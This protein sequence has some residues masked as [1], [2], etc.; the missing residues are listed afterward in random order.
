MSPPPRIKSPDDPGLKVLCDQLAELAPALETED[1]WPAHQLELCGQYGV[2]EWFIPQELGGQGW[3][4]ADVVAGYLKLSEACLTTTFVITQRTGACRRIAHCGN[5]WAREQCL[6]ALIEGR[7]F[8]TVGISH[9]TTS[10]RHLSRPAL[11]A[12]PVDGGIVLD[13]FSPW[14]TGAAFADWIVT[15]AI[16]DDASQ[17]L[18][19]VPRDLAGVTAEPTLALMGLSAS[20]TGPV[21]FDQ[22]EV[23]AS[24]ILAGPAQDV[25]RSGIGA[26]SGG[27]QTSTL[28]TGLSDAAI[29]YLEAQ[30]VDRR[31]LMPIAEAV[32]HEWTVLRDHL[33]QVAGGQPITT[34]ESLRIRANNLV[35]RCTQ[36]AMAAAKG[37][38]YVAGHPVGRWCRE[39][40]FFLVW[41]C[42]QGVQQAGLCE[43]AGISPDKLDR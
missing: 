28:A 18:V 2:F 42:P 12:T 26:S 24:W 17:V 25:M 9:L 13:G 7:R 30:S 41:S 31:E 3:S 38:G 4:D 14:V 32:R 20:Q 1:A 19:A 11:R 35:L 16:L 27:L 22:A 15:G 23:P 6:P 40:L 43:L 8:A 29:G 21:R 5:Q 39:A 34:P 36:A 37:A 33:L 10:R